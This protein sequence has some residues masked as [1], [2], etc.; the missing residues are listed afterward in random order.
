VAGGQDLYVAPDGEIKINQAHSHSFP[1]KATPGWLGWTWYPLPIKQPALTNCNAT[2]PLYDCGTPS[3]YWQFQA[4]NATTGGL[5]ACGGLNS[6]SAV[7][8]YAFTDGFNRTDCVNLM[9]LGTHNY[10]GVNPPVYVY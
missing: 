6:T 3:G 8:L 1:N 2:D 10:T 9:G 4:L 5:A 7:S